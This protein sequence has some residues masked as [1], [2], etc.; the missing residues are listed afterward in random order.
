M[1]VSTTINL[2]RLY[3][4]ISL[5]IIAGEKSTRMPVSMLEITKY[6]EQF[7]IKLQHNSYVG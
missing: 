3:H 5:K 4:Y 6:Q 1:K 7:D 2:K